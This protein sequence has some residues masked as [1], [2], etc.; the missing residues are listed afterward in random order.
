VNERSKMISKLIKNRDT[1]ESYIRSK[2]S[3]LLP[4]QIRSLRLRREMTQAELGSDANMKQAR[5]SVLERIGEVS[6][7]IE[8]LIKISS[9]FRV[10]LIVKFVPMSEMLAWENSFMPDE[11]D[12]HPIEKDTAFTSPEIKRTQIY[13]STLS[14]P[15]TYFSSAINSPEQ[16]R[17]ANV[18]N[19]PID[20][21]EIPMVEPYAKPFFGPST[22]YFSTA[23]ACD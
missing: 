13:V 12:V 3:V 9:A 6:F 20:I 22:G 11:F 1:R 8:T 2:L 17:M 23:K 14:W 10:G 19:S 18:Q 16:I 5:I 21:Q 15:S 7:S 4:A